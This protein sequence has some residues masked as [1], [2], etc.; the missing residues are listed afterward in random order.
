MRTPT[1]YPVDSDDVFEDRCALVC[2]FPVQQH[3]IR[4]DSSKRN[5]R[6]DGDFEAEHLYKLLYGLRED[7]VCAEGDPKSQ[8]ES[9]TAP[10]ILSHVPEK[11][12]DD[13]GG[14]H[15]ARGGIEDGLHVVAGDVGRPVQRRERFRGHC[16]SR[17]PG[18]EV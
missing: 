8:S 11:S 15:P 4:L 9:H 13:A 2:G 14:A 10:Q 1:V 5:E 16:G 18:W 17:V 12:K 6:C 3:A 7:L